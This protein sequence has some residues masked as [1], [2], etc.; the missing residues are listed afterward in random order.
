M[1]SQGS[2]SFEIDGVYFLDRS[3]QVWDRLVHTLFLHCLKVI[4]RT[5]GLVCQKNF[6]Q[7][8]RFF[9]LNVSILNK[10]PDITEMVRETEKASL[11]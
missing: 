3:L 4:G 8:I 5:V 11:M 10:D 1:A 6:P 7:L 2:P 9:L